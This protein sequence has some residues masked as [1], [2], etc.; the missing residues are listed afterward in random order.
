M[1]CTSLT[2]EREEHLKINMEVV[3]SRHKMGLILI[4]VLCYER[5]MSLRIINHFGLVFKQICKKNSTP[6]VC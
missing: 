1:R 3:W 2:L 5:H 6:F 4:H